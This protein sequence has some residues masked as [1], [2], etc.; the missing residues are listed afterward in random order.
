MERDD[1]IE[2]SLNTHHSEEEGKKIR[3]KIWTVTGIL[4]AV[5][6]IEVFL[7][8]KIKQGSD[9]WLM[10]K[11]LFIILTLLKAGYIVLTFMHLGD[12]RKI[13]KWVILIPYFFFIAYL[14]FISLTEAGAVNDA[15]NTY[16]G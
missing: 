5:T 7:G 8:A 12:E 3:S 14:I 2:Y 13:L 10:I 15:W 11:W 1:I 4:T 16:G 6:I 9:Y